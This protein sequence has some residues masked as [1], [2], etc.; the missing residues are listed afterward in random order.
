MSGSRP[1]GDAETAVPA[2]EPVE[3]AAQDRP[4][5]APEPAAEAAMIS[6]R[7]VRVRRSP[8][9]GVFLALGAALGAVVALVAVAVSPVDPEVPTP[10]AL[11]FLILLLA[12]VGALVL[13]GVAVLIDR[14]GE[15]RAKV[16]DAEHTRAGRPDE[17]DQQG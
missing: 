6:Q 14:A 10:Q 1:E 5:A 2:P 16:V 3:D 13:G 12:P 8:R 7:Q 11:G 4:E 17:G 15:R 9:V